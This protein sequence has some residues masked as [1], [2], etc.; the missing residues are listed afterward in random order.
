MIRGPIVSPKI[1]PYFL[2]KNKLNVLTIIKK[3]KQ[4]LELCCENSCIKRIV[5]C[6]NAA[7]IT[8]FSKYPL[9]VSTR[10][11]GNKKEIWTTSEEFKFNEIYFSFAGFDPLSLAWRH[12][13]SNIKNC[14]SDIKKK[15]ISS[16]CEQKSRSP[17][18]PRDLY[19]D[20]RDISRS[21]LFGK[22]LDLFVICSN[23]Y[24]TIEQFGD[25]I[26]LSI[27]PFITGQGFKQWALI[28]VEGKRGNEERG[29]KSK[30][31][32]IQLFEAESED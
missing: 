7:E 22:P 31:L 3:F 23:K 32:E 28:S 24:S 21:H 13:Q 6:E 1:E 16:I 18:I 4:N 8:N 12:V 17:L 11:F 26:V 29:L 30:G 10:V 19:I 14:K 20:P 2:I 9:K 15:M 25:K 27:N 5:F